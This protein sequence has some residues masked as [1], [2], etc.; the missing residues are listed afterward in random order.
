MTDS[1][2]PE[3][4][5]LSHF[6]DPSDKLDLTDEEWKERL[7]DPDYNILRNS[8]TERPFDNKYCHTTTEGVYVCRAC[9]NPLFSSR[10]K[11]HSGSGWPSFYEA[12]GSNHIQKITDYSHFMVR[13]EV[14]CARC[15]SH[16]GHVFDDGPKPTGLRYCM[17]SASLKLID[18]ET[19]RKK[20]V[21]TDIN[22]ANR[23]GASL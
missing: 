4:F 15:N 14:L 8:G 13:T 17:N 9:Q 11:F 10:T 19:Y 6:P 7:P 16:L 22:R 5:E 3:W 21:D 12:V 1:T 18:R 2:L 23:G 20:T